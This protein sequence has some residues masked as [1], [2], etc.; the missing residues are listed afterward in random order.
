MKN[1]YFV[2]LLFLFLFGC[3]SLSKTSDSSSLAFKPLEPSGYVKFNDI[4][5]PAGFKF[6]YKDS[7][8]FETAGLRVAVF[9]Y[10]GS[11]TAEKVFLFFKEQMPIY[12]WNLLNTVEYGIRMLNFERDN[13]SCIITIEPKK[14]STEF[15]ISLGPKQTLLKKEN[16]PIK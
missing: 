8:V 15:I 6:L 9:K 14:F 3:A 5:I 13:E 12:G 7:Y 2:F 16:K 11:P 4:P 1:R 10:S